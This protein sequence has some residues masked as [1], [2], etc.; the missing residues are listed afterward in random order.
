MT[1]I[2]TTTKKH[3]PPVISTNRRLSDL[4]EV[5]SNTLS[6]TPKVRQ[7]RQLLSFPQD[8][9]LEKALGHKTMCGNV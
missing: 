5:L 4:E 3:Q 8:K 1:G 2:T 9:P 7:V 6:E